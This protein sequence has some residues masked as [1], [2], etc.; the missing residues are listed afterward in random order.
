MLPFYFSQ[1]DFGLGPFVATSERAEAIDFTFPITADAWTILVPMGGASSDPWVVARPLTWD[2]W[3]M[4][5]VTVPSIILTLWLL[6][7]GNANHGQSPQRDLTTVCGFVFRSVFMEPPAWA[8]ESTT[9]ER[10]LGWI[11]TSM[12]FVLCCSYAG[13]L[14]SLL[15]KPIFNIPIDRLVGHIKLI[16]HGSLFICI[17]CL[18]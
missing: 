18:S 14:T 15:T 7:M 3:A 4:M 1:A 13:V 10:C 2:V 9:M 12:M 6:R 16:L 17:G 11:W 5:L 8:P